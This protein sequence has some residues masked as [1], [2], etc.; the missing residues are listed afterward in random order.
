MR[1]IIT[2][3][4]HVKMHLGVVRVRIQ[5]ERR[6]TQAHE[7]IH[8]LDYGCLQLPCRIHTASHDERRVVV[9]A[10]NLT[11][12][13]LSTECIVSLSRWFHWHAHGVRSLL[14][15]LLVQCYMIK[16]LTAPP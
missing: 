14:L 15:L 2:R 13:I 9:G 11:T 12:K 1:V 7:V 10:P 6:T 5:V 16:S 8:L 3:H 4:V